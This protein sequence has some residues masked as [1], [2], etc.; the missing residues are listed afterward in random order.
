MF[1]TDVE[2]YPGFPEG[3]S[4]MALAEQMSTHATRYGAEIVGYEV[5]EDFANRARKNVQSFL[6]ADALGGGSR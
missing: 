4:G 2:N 5:R 1:T 6:G 3:I